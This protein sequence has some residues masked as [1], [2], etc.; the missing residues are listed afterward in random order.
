MA[1]FSKAA[2]RNI[3]L[4][5]DRCFDDHELLSLALLLASDVAFSL[6]GAALQSFHCKTLPSS[7][8]QV[9]TS[10]ADQ[11][12]HQVPLSNQI[13]PLVQSISK[14]VRPLN[15]EITASTTL[16]EPTLLSVKGLRNKGQTCYANS[17]FQ[18]LAS[19]PSFCKYLQHLQFKLWSIA[20]SG[21]WQSLAY[22]LYQT[23]QHV[24]GHEISCSRTKRNI[25]SALLSST[26]PGDPQKVLNAVAQHHS[27]FRSRCNMFAGTSEQQDAHE[28]FIA[29]MDVLSE[30]ERSHE[31]LIG[32]RDGLAVMD[33]NISES[34][35]EDVDLG[36]DDCR[37][38]CQ[39]SNHDEYQEEK[40]QCDCDQALSCQYANQYNIE[41]NPRAHLEL[42][43]NPT[44]SHDKLP[45]NST[46]QSPMDGWLGST[47]KCCT[48]RH[49]R[50]VQSTPFA[51]LS[52]TINNSYY[53]VLENCMSLEYGGF[54]AADRVS[55]VLCL[56]C[57]INKELADLREEEMILEGAISRVQQRIARSSGIK[58]QSSKDS[59]NKSLSD[60]S[61]DILGLVKELRQ[62][63]SRASWLRS[64]DPDA[65]QDVHDSEKFS[66]N[67][68]ELMGDNKSSSKPQLRPIRGDAWKATLIMRPPKVLCI[69]T[70]RRQYNPRTGHMVKVRSPVDFSQ[71]MDL[72][73]CF[74]FAE[75]SFE[76]VQKPASSNRIMYRLMSVI[77]H[78]GGAF[79]GHYQTYRRSDWDEDEWV[80]ISDQ[81]VSPRSWNDVKRCEAYMLFYAAL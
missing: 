72:S 27:Q 65:D 18:A 41:K 59:T 40:K 42:T 31:R 64:M 36:G 10:S 69:H 47:L 44:K 50:P 38:N 15:I 7:D 52:I 8:Q 68:F 55:D 80:V 54:A 20:C 25:F 16:E 45:E 17:V 77:E 49:I 22:E 26:Y 35:I 75:N 24:N 67:E 73:G 39:S 29:L 57:A 53:N 78:L 32:T 51:A 1:I 62:I 63:K 60:A 34:L 3:G 11:I 28:F 23:I 79:G 74:A 76:P 33:N 19:L 81:R 56:Q 46:L 9:G 6:F 14:R 58:K 4:S 48:C 2:G 37:G 66:I 61:N 12:I 21:S 13:E 71:V 5:F 30:E 43:T 70:Q